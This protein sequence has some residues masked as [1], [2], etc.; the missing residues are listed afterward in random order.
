M[1][2]QLYNEYKKEYCML[3]KTHKH[4]LPKLNMKS[5]SFTKCTEQMQAMW[6]N[7]QSR[8][9]SLRN[10]NIAKSSRRNLQ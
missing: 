10:K 7:S 4:P 8:R 2:Q 9:I 6:K 5:L 3:R 1:V